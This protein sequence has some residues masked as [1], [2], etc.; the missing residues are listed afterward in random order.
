MYGEPYKKVRQ[1]SP[2]LPNYLQNLILKLMSNKTKGLKIKGYLFLREK[3][4]R[5]T[6]IDQPKTSPTRLST[7][8]AQIKCS[9][10]STH[11]WNSLAFCETFKSKDLS[12]KV[13]VC[14]NCL[15]INNH[16]VQ[17]P[18]KALPCFNCKAAHHTLLCPKV[19]DGQV[20]LVDQIYEDKDDNDPDDERDNI[21]D[22]YN[23]NHGDETQVFLTYYDNDHDDLEDF[24]PKDESLYDVEDSPNDVEVDILTSSHAFLTNS[25]GDTRYQKSSENKS[26]AKTKVKQKQKSNENKSQAKTKV[27]RKQKSS[28][29]KSQAKTKVKRK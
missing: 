20:L 25:M 22:N 19:G 12:I 10:G 15:K 9:Q 11:P 14:V 5:Q 7:S 23:A 16:T 8:H 26:Q 17:K 6:Q 27:K 28:K 4:D 3:G 2:N 29:N 18:C 21:P 1:W 24:D 13:R